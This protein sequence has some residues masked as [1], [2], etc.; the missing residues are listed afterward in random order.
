MEPDRAPLT[1][2]PAML[3]VIAGRST[4]RRIEERLA[5]LDLTMRHLGALGHLV[6]RPEL[7][8]SGLARRAG[9][10]VQSMHATVRRLEEI[11]AV[12]RTLAGQGHPARLDVTLRGRELLDAAREAVAQLDQ[13]LFH[14]LD[15]AQRDTLRAALLAVVGPPGVR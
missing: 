9:V 5:V 13:A 3:L 7:S 6:H 8:Y 4:Q 15:D 10:T 11:G 12:A 14:G 2:S 1:A